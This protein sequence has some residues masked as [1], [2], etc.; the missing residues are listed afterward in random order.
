MS[1]RIRLPSRRSVLG[2][3]LGL[4]ASA[5]LLPAASLRAQPSGPIRLGGLVPM[6]GG[7]GAFGPIMRTVHQAVIEEVNAA[8]G[9]LGRKIE[10]FGEDD[11]TNPE[12]GVRAARKLIDV[13]KVSAILSVWASAVGTAV[14]PLCWENKV[15]LLAISAADSIA[16]LPHQGYFVRT[17]PHT[18]LQGLQ[19]AKFAIARNAKNFYLMMPQTPFTES[20]FKTIYA[21]CEP[22]GIKLSSVIYDAKKTSF[23]SEVD[24]MMRARPDMVMMGGYQPDNIVMAKDIFRANYKGT[25]VGFAY[26]VTPQFVEGAG[27]EVAENIYGIEPIPASGSS[28]YGRLKQI[29]KRDYVDYYGAQ[30]Y[31]QTNLALLSIAKAGEASGTAIRD[32]IRK[33]SDGPGEKVDNAIDGLKLIAAGKEINYEGA[34]GPC[35]FAPNGNIIECE[36]RTTQ[37]KGGKITVPG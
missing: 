11:Q 36:F 22:K 21:E 5:A 33:I 18:V 24:D 27:A 31:D 4:G 34:S 25:V 19:F 35:K 6:T 28:A 32:T 20:V 3:A 17:Q 26:G 15:M 13:D 37:V 8:G 12:A 30:A 10:Y 2:G 23:R 1:T 14:L 7:G 16:D 29:L 9:V